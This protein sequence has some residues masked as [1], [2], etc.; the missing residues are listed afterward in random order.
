MYDFMATWSFLPT[1]YETDGSAI[2]HDVS[3]L[4]SVL[5]AAEESCRVVVA[6]D[7]KYDVP[8]AERLEVDF[9]EFVSHAY[10]T[11]TQL[12]GD[13]LAGFVGLRRRGQ[14]T[15]YRAA[16]RALVD[17]DG[18]IIVHKGHVGEAVPS[19]LR[20]LGCRAPIYLQFHNDPS[21]TITS[22]ELRRLLGATDGVICVSDSVRA[23]ISAR[24]GSAADGIPMTTVYNSVDH[25]RFHPVDATTSCVEPTTERPPKILFM[26]AMAPH[27]GP[28]VLL[29]ALA[30]LDVATTLF[31]AVLVGS[32]RHL[33]DLPTTRFER[34]LHA[35]AAKLGGHIRF[36]PF[37]PHAE[38]PDVFRS[39]DILVMPSQFEEPFG[40]VL[41]EGM[42]SG[43]AVV[44][45]H[46]GGIPEVGGDAIQYFDGPELLAGLLKELIADRQQRC[47]WG[48]RAVERSKRFT[49]AR[50]VGTLRAFVEAT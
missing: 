32:S 19:A 12:R 44:A 13:A 29:D 28:Q 20:R 14:E 7:R 47:A 23:R 5:S 30:R 2:H 36:E 31:E 17:A 49:A 27:K 8:G 42:A 1:P 26:G 46:K 39:A 38:A 33:T 50:A 24:L 11:P 34:H 10:L 21:R 37:R 22:R 4:V 16:L 9:G 3:G 15:F 48:A 41:L 43:L 25:T 40:L 6:H 18:P 35:R 45:T